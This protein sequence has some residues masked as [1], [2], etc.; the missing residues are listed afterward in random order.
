MNY[1]T[2]FYFYFNNIIKYLNQKI[3]K[4][5]KNFLLLLFFLFFGFLTGNLFGTLIENIK[6]IYLGNTLLIIII[7]LMNEFINFFTYNTKNSLNLF[8]LYSFLNAFKIGI[9]L[10][11]FIDSYKVGS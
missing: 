7:I 10:G 3:F 2:R 6:F 9:L 5:K 4:L 11:F 8:K 1:L